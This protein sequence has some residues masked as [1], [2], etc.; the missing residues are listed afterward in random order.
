M[1]WLRKLRGVVTAELLG[2]VITRA[3]LRS[4]KLV[5]RDKAQQ[6][7]L[8]EISRQQR[9]GDVFTGIIPDSAKIHQIAQEE[10]AAAAR[11]PE[12]RA[13]FDSVARELERKAST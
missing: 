1:D 7:T 13:M 5:A 10:Q 12:I 4:G 2:I 8:K 3:K 11:D 6:G 9:A